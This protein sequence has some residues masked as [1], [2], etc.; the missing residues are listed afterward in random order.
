MM[1]ITKEKTSHGG[2]VN[3]FVHFAEDAFQIA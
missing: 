1:Q 3:W 2:G